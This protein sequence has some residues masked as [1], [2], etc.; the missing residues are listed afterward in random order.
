MNGAS[1]HG[2]RLF[3][4][5]LARPWLSPHAAPLRE[6]KEAIVEGAELIDELAAVV[7]DYL[8]DLSALLEFARRA[9]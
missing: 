2:P 3:C 5:L 6:L 4:L 1:C 8:I 9:R 7:V